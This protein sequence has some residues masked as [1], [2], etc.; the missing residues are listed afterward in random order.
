MSLKECV[1]VDRSRI[2][3]WLNDVA[4]VTCELH[5]TI[6]ILNSFGKPGVILIN[7]WY[8]KFNISLH[9]FFIVYG[10]YCGRNGLSMKKLGKF[11]L[12]RFWIKFDNLL[13]NRSSE[14]DYKDAYKNDTV[15]TRMILY[16]GRF[17]KL[18]NLLKE[19][20]LVWFRTRQ[21]NQSRNIQNNCNN[22]KVFSFLIKHFLVTLFTTH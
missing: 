9:K 8:G 22:F 2:M 5:I 14:D 16:V 4:S 17:W 18:Q 3:R 21:S 20:W 19:W 13:D 7:F 11:Q 6:K 10:C 1:G 15:S 12:M